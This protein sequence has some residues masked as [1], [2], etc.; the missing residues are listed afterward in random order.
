MH[1]EEQLQPDRSQSASSRRAFLITIDTE[2]DDL[3]SKPSDITVRNAES[4]PRFQALCDRY[5]LKPTYLANWEMA[6]SAAFVEFGRAVL[7]SGTA[8]IG[9]HLHAWNSP[10]V[11]PLTIDD[12]T[13]QPY[14]MEYPDGIIREKVKVMTETLEDKFGVKMR[15]HRAGRWGLSGTYVRVLVDAGYHVDCSVTPHVDWRRTMGDPSGTGGPDF[16]GFPE[17]AY[18]IDPDTISRPGASPLLEV[19]M[20]IVRLYDSPWAHSLRASLGRVPYVRR[21]VYRHRP[22]HTWLRA[23]GTSGPELRGI[24]AVAREQGRD[25]VE[26]MAHSSELMAGGSPWF[27]T[28]DQIERLYENLE[29]LYEASARDWVGYT[30][31]DYHDTL[32]RSGDGQPARKSQPA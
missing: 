8:E 6:T 22:T 5:G 4:L 27:R 28:Q 31:S 15:S 16:R 21:S 24:L 7:A 29:T 26:F 18:F 25:Y 23:V 20:T 11:V 3:W 2:G 13:H 12:F 9:M 32:L 19:P 30:L 17:S 14:L 10:P 1:H